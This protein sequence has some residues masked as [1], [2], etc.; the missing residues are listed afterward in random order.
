MTVDLVG[1]MQVSISL[2][3]LV[4]AGRETLGRLLGIDDP[5]GISVY[6]DRHYADGNVVL[7]VFDHCG[8]EGYDGP[9]KRVDATFTPARTCAG[10]VLA[11]AL[12]LAAAERGDGEFIDINIWMLL[13]PEDEPER[14][15]ERSKLPDRGQDFGQR[16]ARYMRQFTHLEGWPPDPHSTD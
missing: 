13:P 8:K 6:V 12:A 14:A 2:Q 1:T 5:P 15:I 9:Q 10:V 11:T 4:A 7:M 3:E 16:C